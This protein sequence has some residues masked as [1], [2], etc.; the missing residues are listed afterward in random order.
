M[1]I[2]TQGGTAP[3]STPVPP[4]ATSVPPTATSV[5][6]TATSV[7]PTPTNTPVPGGEVIYMSSTTNGNVGFAFNDEDIVAY[8]SSSGAW[9]MYFDGSDVG[10][11]TDVNGFAF[12]SDGSILM[13]MDTGTTVPGI[14]SVD[15]SDIV[16]FYPTSL[17]DNTAGTFGFFFDGS[18]VELTTSSEDIDA[19]TV[20]PDGRLVIS[21][22]GS[23][24]VTGVSSA[25][26][27]LLVFTAT[28][29]GTNT[30]GSWALY[31]DGSDVGLTA[32]T[33]DI[34]GA[35]VKGSDTYLST[36]GAFSVTGLS[37]DG[38]DIFVC[39]NTTT[40]TN[41]AC[42]SFSMYWDGSTHGFTGEIIDGF[43]IVP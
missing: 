4:T 38:A 1:E 28:S 42:G 39:A 14:G 11:T 20:L 7:P 33:E 30:S 10:I 8:T 3:T 2:C 22:I 40:G 5:P 21:T 36:N 16:Q 17:G 43:R 12:L 18:D 9:S 41:T 29:L 24:T 37:G 25:D 6:P 15:D 34:F 19:M 31:F 13:T 32:T 23:A 27:D 26:E 35:Y